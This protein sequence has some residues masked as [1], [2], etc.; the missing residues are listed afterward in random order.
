MNIAI[1][2]YGVEGKASLAYWQA[3]GDTIT[4]LDEC[5]VSDVP[6]GVPVV[7]GPQAFDMLE[8]FDMV[9][10]T[11]SLRPDKLHSARRVWS[12]TNEFFTECP[13][14]IIGVTGTKGKGTTASLIAAI[15]RATGRTVHL[16]GNIGVAALEVL[17]GIAPDDVVVYELSSFQ[18]WDLERSPRIAVV[19]MVEPDHLDIH[20][21]FD[22]YLSTKANITRYQTDTDVVVYHPT[23]EYAQTIALQSAARKVRYGTMLD[24]GV[25]VSS[26]KFFVQTDPICSVSVLQIAGV[27]NLE[28]ACAAI[29][30]VLAYEPQLR[31]KEVEIEQGLRAFE[32]LPHRLKFIREVR[33]VKYYDD[34]IATTPGS[35][36]A[37]LHSFSEPKVIILGGSDKGIS[38]DN[39]IMACQQT[40]SSIVATGMTGETIAQLAQ[41][42]G[43]TCRRVIGQM[44][45]AVEAAAELAQIGG[46]VILSPASASFDQYSDY[47]D[48]GNQ[49]IAAVQ[50]LSE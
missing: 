26:D 4:V 37:A 2:G 34:S 24:G 30:A 5:N 40:G 22:E 41:A 48:R 18:L 35:A 43:V 12:A 11:A 19:L 32:G 44:D 28:N 1:A 25:Y 21:D 7:S 16:V 20:S 45:E 33:G 10:R 9:I 14:P 27:H 38:Y 46:V 15:L 39:V 8:R 50:S 13:A 17:P 36:I 29:S 42:A 47:A 3:R 49:F 6:H 31:S 23:N